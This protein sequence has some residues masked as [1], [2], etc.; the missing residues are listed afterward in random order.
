MDRPHDRFLW[1]NQRNEFPRRCRS[2]GS[3]TFFQEFKVGNLDLEPMKSFVGRNPFSVGCNVDRTQHD[4]RVGMD[5]S[6]NESQI[7]QFG[8]S[9]IEDRTI[10]TWVFN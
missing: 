1:E 7:M 8:F 2:V 3:S 5:S 10:K 6:G 4:S 9:E